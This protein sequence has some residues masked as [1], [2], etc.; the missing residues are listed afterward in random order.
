[1]RECAGWTVP[2]TLFSDGPDAEL[3]PF[4]AIGNVRRAPALSDVGHLLLLSRSQVIVASAGSTFS[5][6]AG[7]LSEAALILH[8]DH[9]HAPVRPTDLH[10]RLYEGP[11]LRGWQDWSE[12]LIRQVRSVPRTQ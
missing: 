10:D 5:M 9:I 8:P 2:A 12:P 1:M 11:A 3:S 7:F 4:L 6:W